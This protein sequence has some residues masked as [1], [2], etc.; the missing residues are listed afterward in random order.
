MQRGI[1]AALTARERDEMSAMRL[2]SQ[3][4]PELT[5]TIAQHNEDKCTDT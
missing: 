1:M 4:R 5:K 3:D 2:K